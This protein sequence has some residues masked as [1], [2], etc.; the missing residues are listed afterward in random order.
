MEKKESVV[1]VA[2]TKHGSEGLP[3]RKV[4]PDED[5]VCTY[6]GRRYPLLTFHASSGSG[7]NQKYGSDIHYNFFLFFE[8]DLDFE[9]GAW[10]NFLE[11]SKP[12]F[13]RFKSS[14]AW[15]GQRRLIHYIVLTDADS[16]LV[17]GNSNS[18]R[19]RV[20]S[21]NPNNGIHEAIGYLL[22]ESFYYSNVYQYRVFEKGVEVPPTQ[23]EDEW[24]ALCET[25]E[26]RFPIDMSMSGVWKLNIDGEVFYQPRR[27]YSD[28]LK[29]GVA[30]RH[31]N[32]HVLKFF[33]LKY[34]D[35]YVN[36]SHAGCFVEKVYLH[37]NGNLS[38]CRMHLPNGM[39]LMPYSMVD[40]EGNDG[41]ISAMGVV[42]EQQ[43]YTQKRFPGISGLNGLE[44]SEKS[45]NDNDSI[46][47]GSFVNE[48]TYLVCN[49]GII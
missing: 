36:M 11:Q 37:D 24:D 42:R 6:F 20:Y 35:K 19:L 4:V 2:M 45:S 43:L 48:H 3:M 27:F 32:V 22:E 44:H 49:V 18:P 30:F 21:R 47:V 23:M 14:K 46:I 33:D 8:D 13:M 26:G 16:L 5:G 39:M 10:R 31:S 34:F 40:A 9:K 17:S 25:R 41:N 38:F 12:T 7:R 15:M 29:S 1:I 28:S